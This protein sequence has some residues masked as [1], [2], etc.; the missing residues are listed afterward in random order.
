MAPYRWNFE[1]Y[2]LKIRIRV[3]HKSN[4]SRSR[5]GKDRKWLC[6]ASL[7]S[8][9]TTSC[10]CKYEQPLHHMILFVGCSIGLVRAIWE[11]VWHPS[12]APRIN[13]FPDPIDRT[14]STAFVENHIPP[15]PT[16]THTSSVLWRGSSPFHANFTTL[17]P[18]KKLVDK[19]SCGKCNQATSPVDG[20]KEKRPCLNTAYVLSHHS[21]T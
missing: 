3:T 2:L 13:R 19:L 6:P 1:T 14:N 5:I 9:G 15:P 20:K 10:P 12:V 17:H 18:E 21:K 16:H 8:W 4:R 11:Y 7:V